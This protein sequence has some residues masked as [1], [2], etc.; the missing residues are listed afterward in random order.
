M[1]LEYEKILK[2]NENLK[3]KER[4]LNKKIEN[5]ECNEKEL[6][7]EIDNLNKSLR[8]E[9]NEKESILSKLKNTQDEIKILNIDNNKLNEEF[10]NNQKLRN[11]LLR[12]KS[13]YNKI[14]A[15]NKDYIDDLKKYN[16]EIE[17]LKKEKK[18]MVNSLRL[19]TARSSLIESKFLK[20]DNSNS[21]DS[22]EPQYSKK[23]CLMP[24][25]DGSGNTKNGKKSHRT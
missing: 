19:L 14:C 6:F 15:L 21:N 22:C 24:G 23:Q 25:C 18:K 16:K 17:Q 5:K 1:E 2:E 20:H 7:D 13:S 11:E 8:C 10:R 3:E 12:C 4:H 9:L